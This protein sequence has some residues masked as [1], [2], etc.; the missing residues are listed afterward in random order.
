MTTYEG[1]ERRVSGD[2]ARAAWRE[3]YMLA[4]R[5]KGSS[6]NG[7]VWKLAALILPPLLGVGIAAI[8]M[9]GDVAVL[10]AGQAAIHEELKIVT[11][12]HEQVDRLL[13]E[14]GVAIAKLDERTR[15]EHPQ[16]QYGP[17]LVAPAEAA[18]PL[19]ADKE[20]P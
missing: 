2:E 7:I 12:N 4:A 13:R 5:A 11:G 3:G 16:R 8:R 17:P 1:P 15:A 19:A 10:K 6:A 9:H 18:A 20:K 14:F